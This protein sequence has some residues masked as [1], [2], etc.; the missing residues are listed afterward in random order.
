MDAFLKGYFK[1]VEWM[2]N[3]VAHFPLDQ[4]MKDFILTVDK[5]LKEKCKQCMKIICDARLQ[6][7]KTLDDLIA[8]FYVKSPK[9]SKGFAIF[10]F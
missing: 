9:D 5:D 10:V 7:N 8:E 3:R 6:A 2:V 4:K 1:V